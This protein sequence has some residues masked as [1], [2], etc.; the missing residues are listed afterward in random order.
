MEA[1]KT[2]VTTTSATSVRLIMPS[3]Y[4]QIRHRVRRFATRPN[5]VL[6]GKQDE[7]C[8]LYACACFISWIVVRKPTTIKSVRRSGL[9]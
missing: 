9:D 8:A 1:I 2:A 6:L 4:T 5:P 3:K 7:G